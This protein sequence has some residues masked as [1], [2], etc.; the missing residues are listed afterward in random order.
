[1]LSTRNVVILGGAGLFFAYPIMKT[2][3][4]R[5]DVIAE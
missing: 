3:E 4:H 2:R 1:M 5:K